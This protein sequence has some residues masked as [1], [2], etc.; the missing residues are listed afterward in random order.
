MLTAK[1]NFRE[2]VNGGNPDRYVNQY[3]ALQILF[4]PAMI[5]GGPMPGPGE[6]NVTNGWGVTYSW[7]EGQ[8]GSFPEHG[9]DKLLVKDIATKST[10]RVDWQ[11]HKLNSSEPAAFYLSTSE[12]SKKK[13]STFKRGQ[14]IYVQL[15][16]W[17]AKKI[18]ATITTTV[19]AENSGGTRR[20]NRTTAIKITV[21]M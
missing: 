13:V 19:I 16:F 17:N 20:Y 1:E 3:E 12:K 2:C 6:M 9:K 15:N 11:F 18:K 10:A 21:E 5:L 14:K 4:H 8:P 7:P